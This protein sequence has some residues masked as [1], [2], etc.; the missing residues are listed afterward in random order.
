MK[1][2]IITYSAQIRF[3]GERVYFSKAIDMNP[4]D[5]FISIKEREE[6]Q[7][8]SYYVEFVLNFFSE[9]SREQYAKLSA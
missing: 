1:Y 8:L 2:Y 3:S 6:K 9:I 7:E 4:V 5:Y